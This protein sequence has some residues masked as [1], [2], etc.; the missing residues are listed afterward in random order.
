[1]KHAAVGIIAPYKIL[2]NTCK[3]LAKNI[4]KTL[5][6]TMRKG[7]IFRCDFAMG[8]D[9]VSVEAQHR[10]E[11]S[12]VCT[13]WLEVDLFENRTHKFYWRVCEIAV[14]T[15]AG[16]RA[17]DKAH[18]IFLGILCQRPAR[19]PVTGSRVMRCGRH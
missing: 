11:A 10:A 9:C 16:V 15:Q 7:V 5:P 1:M 6:E 4:R 8:K 14:F 19:M 17:H 12:A 2:Q 3:I 18:E 13:A